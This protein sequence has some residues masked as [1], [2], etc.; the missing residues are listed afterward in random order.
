MERWRWMN[1]H[2]RHSRQ[3]SSLLS[4]WKVYY[5]LEISSPNKSTE[6]TV[7]SQTKPSSVELEGLPADNWSRFNWR[8]LETKRIWTE[9][10][11]GRRFSARIRRRISTKYTVRL[12]WEIVQSKR[13]NNLQARRRWFLKTHYKRYRLL[14][15]TTS[16]MKK[17]LSRISHKT[18]ATFTPLR[19]CAQTEVLSV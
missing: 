10:T 17:A 9:A 14:T 5:R 16:C 4:R 19:P 2:L 3:V 11:A 18:R 1:T 7:D 13:C 8:I 12:W 6:T 15:K